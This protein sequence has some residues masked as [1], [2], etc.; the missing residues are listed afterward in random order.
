[1]NKSH[2]LEWCIL[3]VLGLFSFLFIFFFST[4]TSPLY[5]S[6]PFWFHGD[7]GIFQEMGL[8]II[9]GGTPYVD[10]FD[11][12]GPILFFIEAL[13]LL[14][15]K[16]WG[17]F[18]IQVINLF[19]VLIVWKKIIG[20]FV[21]KWYQ[22]L[23]ILI[24]SLFFLYSF[25]HRGNLTEDWSLLFISLPLYYFSRSIRN[26]NPMSVR[27]LF[28]IGLC[29]GVIFFIRANNAAPVVGVII[30]Y[31]FNLLLSKKYRIL[32]KSILALSSGIILISIICASV[33]ILIYD[34]FAFTEM[35]F[36]TFLFNFLYMSGQAGPGLSDFDF[37]S[38]L[39]ALLVLSIISFRKESKLF[40]SAI[41]LSYI[42]SIFAIGDKNFLHYS[43]IFVPLFCVSLCQISI[44][45]NWIGF[46][47]LGVAL[48]QCFRL[49]YSGG[50]CLAFRLRGKEPEHQVCDKF[51]DF[52]MKVDFDERNEI[53]NCD[54]FLPFYFA[55]E[56][57]VQRNRFVLPGHMATAKHLY[58]YEKEH[59]IFEKKPAWVLFP[60][61]SVFEKSL[62]KSII[63]WE[64]FDNE[65][66]LA[67]SIVTDHTISYCYKRLNN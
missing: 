3:G 20:L 55:Q 9:Q 44:R 36:G 50:D 63:D 51:H 25:Y 4:T 53:Y 42:I 5:A 26:G 32:F 27:D 64:K 10:L 2:G 24:C 30:A 31:F 28:N 39:I 1:M 15:N 14:I 6:H 21:Q 13:G 29:I 48:F 22:I 37:Y 65:Y 67:D 8:C 58:D 23:S 61:K 60:S 56:K 7:S 18:F 59:G 33:F 57:I 17:L 62:Y 19:C 35:V 52:I 54:A 38:P 46:L 43:M 16:E 40:D 66:Y 47:I 49:G 41:I 12:K 45:K 34:W 11:H